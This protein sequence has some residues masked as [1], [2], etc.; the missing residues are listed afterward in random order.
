MRDK[1][2][3]TKAVDAAK[4]KARATRQELQDSI[5]KNEQ[6]KQMLKEERRKVESLQKNGFQKTA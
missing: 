2:A 3:N 1:L 5:R 6:L 4:T